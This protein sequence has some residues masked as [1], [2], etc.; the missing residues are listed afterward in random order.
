[1][2]LD[3]PSNGLEAWKRLVRLGEGGGGVKRA[4]LLRQVLK[5]DFSDDFMDNLG[6]REALGKVYNQ[7]RID[8]ALD[9]EVLVAVVIDGATGELEEHT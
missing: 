4:G 6:S 5:Y 3:E 1:M 8:N 7:R 9:D 2:N